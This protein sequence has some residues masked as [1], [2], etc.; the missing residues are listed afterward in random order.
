MEFNT[1]YSRRKTLFTELP[2]TTRR[3]IALSSYT[4]GFRHKSDVTDNWRYKGYAHSQDATNF[5]PLANRWTVRSGCHFGCMEYSKGIQIVA[6][7]ID[8]ATN[9]QLCEPEVIVEYLHYLRI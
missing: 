8:N 4:S 5:K 3:P 9:I 2:I 1:N 7:A 6:S